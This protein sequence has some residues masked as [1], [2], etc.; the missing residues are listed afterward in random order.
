MLTRMLCFVIGHAWR[1]TP[2]PDADTADAYYLACRR[3]G[4]RR[5]ARTSGVDGGMAAGF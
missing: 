2:D 3:C 1:R 5:E 4:R